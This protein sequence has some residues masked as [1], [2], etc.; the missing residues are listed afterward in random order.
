M[1]GDAMGDRKLLRTRY[2]GVVGFAVLLL[3]SACAPRVVPGLSEIKE[4]KGDE[5][6]VAF[7]AVARDINAEYD[8]ESQK[9]VS[10]TPFKSCSRS[11]SPLGGICSS[12]PNGLRSFTAEAGE[13]SIH[14]AWFFGG[15]QQELRFPSIPMTVEK[16]KI[17]YIGTV[18]FDVVHIRRIYPDQSRMSF[19]LRIKIDGDFEEGRKQLLEHYSDLGIDV[20]D[21]T[22]DTDPLLFNVANRFYSIKK[23]SWIHNIDEL[24][25]TKSDQLSSAASK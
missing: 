7:R 17:N 16:G 14:T 22:I 20:V 6:V 19:Y 2:V 15:E 12:D 9:I 21:E 5:G 4:L 18:Y 25:D 24:I 8:G 13:R 10:I 3:L 23:R 11:V 1:L